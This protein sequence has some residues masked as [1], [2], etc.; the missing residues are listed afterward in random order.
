[1]GHRWI[2]RR[3]HPR[4]LSN[5]KTTEV[6]ASWVLKHSPDE[7]KRLSLRHQCPMCGA[8]VVT[9]RMPNGGS[10]HFEGGKGLSRIKHACLHLGERLS[11]KRDENTDDLFNSCGDQE[12]PQ[13]RDV[14]GDSGII[15][16][17]YGQDW[18][19]VEFEKG[20]NRFYRYTYLST[21][22]DHVEKM[23]RLADAGEGLNSYINRQ[24]ARRYASKH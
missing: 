4:R 20:A 21:G 22:S 15:G 5:G 7:K 2:P 17:E 9:V 12:M 6:R 8:E 3:S 14:D 10:A 11:R 19:E 13:Y 18:I 1:M 23:K 16:Y 24:V